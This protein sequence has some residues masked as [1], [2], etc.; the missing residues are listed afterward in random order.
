MTSVSI[1]H[2]NLHNPNKF[3]SDDAKCHDGFKLLC[4]KKTS[5]GQ[6]FDNC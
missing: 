6:S 5:V 4:M 2:M 1:I 3:V